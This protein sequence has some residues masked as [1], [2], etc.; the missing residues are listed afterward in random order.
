LKDK[1]KIGM[2]FRFFKKTIKKKLRDLLWESVLTEEF[3]AELQKK[4]VQHHTTNCRNHTTI[5]ITSFFYEQSRVFNFQ[6]V[7][8]NITIQQG[9]HI[10]GELLL[11]PFGGKNHDRREL[12]YWRKY[13]YMVCRRN[14]YW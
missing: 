9:T 10:R 6:N 5:D 12:L 11:F 7:K 13:S 8:E 4:Y 1:I 14:N 3:A 2:M